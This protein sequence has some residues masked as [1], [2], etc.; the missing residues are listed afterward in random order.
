[1]AELRNA[2]VAVAT[3]AEETVGGYVQLATIQTKLLTA[4]PS[5]S[6]N[7]LDFYLSTIATHANLF[8][9]GRGRVGKIATSV[10]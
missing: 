3:E 5:L 1:M 6:G 4:V 9:N 7:A 8:H 10:R 2:F